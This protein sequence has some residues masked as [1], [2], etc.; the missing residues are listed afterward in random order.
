M[1]T[2]NPYVP[3]AEGKVRSIKECSAFILEVF[4]TKEKVRAEREEKRTKRK[5]TETVYI[6]SAKDN[7]NNNVEEVPIITKGF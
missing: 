4:K 1:G 6:D 7:T 2:G 3:R 5:N